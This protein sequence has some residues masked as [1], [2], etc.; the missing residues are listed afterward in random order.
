MPRPE[1]P[2]DQPANPSLPA[3]EPDPVLDPTAGRSA[4]RAARDPEA[5]DQTDPTR[6]SD[7]Q[8]A[9]RLPHETDPTSP[10]QP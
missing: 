6:S 9:D 3:T 8:E 4:R 7:R 2:K 10:A 5:L 1:D